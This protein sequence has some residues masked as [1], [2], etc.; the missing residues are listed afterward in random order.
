VC[1]STVSDIAYTVL[2]RRIHPH[3]RTAQTLPYV[4]ESGILTEI[5]DSVAG[6]PVFG[7]GLGP[8][9]GRGKGDDGRP[10]PLPHTA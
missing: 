4:E 9:Q 5:K 1:G 10:A 2:W 7:T 8:P 3:L 6:L